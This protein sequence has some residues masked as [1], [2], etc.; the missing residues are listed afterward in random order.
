MGWGGGVGW[1]SGVGGVVGWVGVGGEE[2]GE[3]RWVGRRVGGREGGVAL[4][5]PLVSSGTREMSD[6]D[7]RHQHH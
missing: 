3:R 4:A 5:L 6:W 7:S 1:D 2:E